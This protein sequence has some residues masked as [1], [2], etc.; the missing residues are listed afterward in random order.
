MVDRGE[1]VG[2]LTESDVLDGLLV[3]LGGSQAAPAE[4]DGGRCGVPAGRNAEG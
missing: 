4:H 1:L 2:L 3:V